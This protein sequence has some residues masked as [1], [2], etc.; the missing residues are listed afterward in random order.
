M[1]PGLVPLDQTPLD[2]SAAWLRRAKTS[3]HISYL[4]QMENDPATIWRKK[5][6][7]YSYFVIPMSG[8]FTVNL[9]ERLGFEIGQKTISACLIFSL[10]WFCL[11]RWMKS[12]IFL[13]WR[14]N[15]LSL[16]SIVPSFW[17]ECSTWSYSLSTLCYNC[18]CASYRLPSLC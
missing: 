4:A 15:V 5:P 3:C 13:E 10:W 16:N 1:R 7:L 18:V 11:H 2:Q 8:A 17:P 6:R 14:E 9:H 12:Y